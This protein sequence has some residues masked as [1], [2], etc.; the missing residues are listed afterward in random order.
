VGSLH[1][2][3]C[4]AGP[5]ELRPA[6][7][8]AMA[9]FEATRGHPIER[10]VWDSWTVRGASDG[11]G[12][13][14]AAGAEQ[15]PRLIHDDPHYTG[16][17]L[18]SQ[19]GMC[20]G[21]PVALLDLAR[22]YALASRDA[23][24]SWRLWHELAATL[25]APRTLEDLRAEYG[26]N[27]TASELYRQ[28]PLIT[29]FL[30]RGADTSIAHRLY[31][32]PPDGVPEL[33]RDRDDFVRRQVARNARRTD[34]LTVDGWWIDADGR[35]AHRDGDIRPPDGPFDI[36]G[37]LAILPGDTIVVTLKCHT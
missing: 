22:P 14:I 30:L 13:F 19:P 16:R 9:P 20:A 2:T 1:V 28:Q 4:L 26:S 37:Y 18:P 11:T 6:L 29:A 34:L 35:G 24:R 32:L 3:V 8:A 17:E 21:G 10:D 15:D 25:P 7:D 31:G 23:E 12:F 33:A 27:L 36:L 5:V